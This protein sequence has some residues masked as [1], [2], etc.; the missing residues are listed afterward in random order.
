VAFWTLRDHFKNLISRFTGAIIAPI[1]FAAW[2]VAIAQVMNN[3]LINTDVLILGWFRGATDVGY[4]SAANRILQIF[5]LLPAILGLSTIPLFARLVENDREKFRRVLERLLTV[6]LLAAIPA[7]VGGL[8]LGK[9]VMVLIFGGEYAPAGLPFQILALTLV[10]G[11]ASGILVNA[12]FAHNRQKHLT[13]YSAIAGVSNVLFDLILI[14]H[15]GMIGSS[16]ATLTSELISGAYIWYIMKHTQY[17]EIVPH[18]KNIMLG[19]LVM[20]ATIL[21]LLFLHT[22]LILNIALSSCVYFGILYM[23]RE[24]VLKEI[25]SIFVPSLE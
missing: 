16:F 15:Y 2:P 4:Y 3:L 25:R 10:N 8:I 14:P 6:I 5:Y 9:A 12:V 1:L 13:A 17:F 22:P 24:P 11:F 18:L 21:T 20:G 19:T 23:R 7:A